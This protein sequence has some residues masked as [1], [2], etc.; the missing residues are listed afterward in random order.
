MANGGRK[1]IVLPSPAANGDRPQEGPKRNKYGAKPMPDPEGGQRF[2]STLEFK[3]ATEL[4]KMVRAGEITSV[5]RQVLVLLPGGVEWTIDFLIH[6]ND[7]SV[8]YYETKGKDTPD[9]LIKEKLFREKYPDYR[10]TI[11]Y[12]K[13]KREGPRRK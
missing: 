7:G 5:S 3:G 9:F 12:A 13:V 2:P 6:H 10:L 11:K 1:G 8:E 4:R